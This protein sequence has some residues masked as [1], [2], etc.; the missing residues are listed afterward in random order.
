MRSPLIGGEDFEASIGQ[1]EQAQGMVME[2]Y[3]GGRK[4]LGWEKE[5]GFVLMCGKVLFMREMCAIIKHG[6]ISRTKPMEF[7]FK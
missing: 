1:G 4:A 2:V 5:K 3:Q 7:Y 6:R